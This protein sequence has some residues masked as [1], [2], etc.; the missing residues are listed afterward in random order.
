MP[1]V[2][3]TL[4]ALRRKRRPGVPLAATM[5]VAGIVGPS[6]CARADERS[7]EAEACFAAAEAAQPMLRARKLREARYKLEVCARDE[8]PRA[9]RTD[10]RRWLAQVTR[11]LPT[12]V[13]AAREE[14]AGGESRPLRD[15]RVSIDGEV[16]ATKLDGEPVFVDAGVHTV[17]FERA[18]NDAAERRVELLEGESGR[19]IEVVFHAPA[20]PRL[21]TE[22]PA[23]QREP[24]GVSSGVWVPPASPPHAVH[25]VPAAAIALG[26]AGAVALVIGVVLEAIGLSDRQHLVDTC[27][28]DRSCAP[29][30]VGEARSRVMAGDVALGASAILSAAAAYVYFTRDAGARGGRSSALRLR[31]GS[32]G[33]GLAT[34]VEGGL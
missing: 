20:R 27:Q 17:R 26:S 14:D 22:E 30:D 34:G 12:V 1:V 29:S 23:A 32:T 25:A 13:F 4:C 19:A 24:R 9:A 6:P 33:A 5:V 21:R 15:V 28:A 16:V 18:P 8:C 7:Q 31:I 11:E 2:A 10:C 3:R